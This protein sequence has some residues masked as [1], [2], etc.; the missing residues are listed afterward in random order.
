VSYP[1]IVVGLDCDTLDEPEQTI[2][3]GQGHV[4]YHLRNNDE[5]L[6]GVFV[7]PGDL[8]S[9]VNAATP[10][11]RGAQ[12]AGVERDEEFQIS[13][14]ATQTEYTPVV[15]SIKQN[16]STY[17]SSYLDYRGVVLLR[18]EAAVQGVNSV[19]VWDCALQCYDRRFIEE[20]DE[21]V[22]GHHVSLFF[23]PF[24]EAKQNKSVRSFLRYVGRDN[25]DGFGA[26]A[27]AAGLLFRDVV[28][29]VVAADGDNGLTR[30]R[31]LEE[32]AQVQDFT[33]EVDGEGI[34]PPTDVGARKVA[35][36][37]AVLQVRDGKFVRVYPK[38]KA[39]FDCKKRNVTAIKF[40]LG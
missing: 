6:H 40:A 10:P 16:K 17:V 34:L 5:D 39:T 25:A 19:V 33:A 36:C 32:A 22:E 35:G 8:Q 13:G 38:E 30:A 1:I 15:Q 21:E 18:K 11:V 4:L 28:N 29:A 24:E 7:I 3:T 23:V 12:K 20:G 37:V 14:L 9:T 2:R 26:Q 27:W 31:F